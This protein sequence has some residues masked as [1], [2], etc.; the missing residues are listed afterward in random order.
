MSH[1]GSMFPFSS[2]GTLVFLLA[3]LFC[4]CEVPV[5][6]CLFSKVTDLFAETSCTIYYFRQR[7]VIPEIQM[8]FLQIVWVYFCLHD[9]NARV[10]LKLL[11]LHVAK[12]IIVISSKRKINAHVEFY[13]ETLKGNSCIFQPGSYSNHCDHADSSIM[14]F[15]PLLCISPVLLHPF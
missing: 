15:A 2:V 14:L 12:R 1:H 5:M 10:Q 9:S 11:A 13:D 8:K 7:Y 6:H 4:S 3:D